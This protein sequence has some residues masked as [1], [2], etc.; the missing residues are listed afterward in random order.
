MPCVLITGFGPFRDR[1]GRWIDP[2]PSGEVASRLDGRT[3]ARRPVVGVQLPV[4]YKAVAL[5]MPELLTRLKPA[6]VIALG[7]GHPDAVRLE[8]YASRTATSDRPDN[9]G[10]VLCGVPVRAGGP[11]RLRAPIDATRLATLL[12]RPALPVRPST[13]AGGFV[14]NAAFY[15]LLRARGP[16]TAACFVHLPATGGLD[17]LERLVSDLAGAL[18]TP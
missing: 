4:T 12:D 18:L 14:C 7:A 16:A 17:A 13:D 15:A 9:D 1:S 6:L 8:Q 3:L 10:E 2:N 5:A 11:D